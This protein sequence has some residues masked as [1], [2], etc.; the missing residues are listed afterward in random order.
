MTIKCIEGLRRLRQNKDYQELSI[1]AILFDL[2]KGNGPE[3]VR[4]E[5]DDVIERFD[6]LCATFGEG[7]TEQPHV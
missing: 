3:T 5:L 4:Y 7:K 2:V 1:E 6:A